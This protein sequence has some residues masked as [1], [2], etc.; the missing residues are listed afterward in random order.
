MPLPI[1]GLVREEIVG[2]NLTT[3]KGLERER[4]KHVESEAAVFLVSNRSFRVIHGM[5][6]DDETLQTSDINHDVIGWKI[7]QD[8]SLRLV[9][10]RKKASKC[11]GQ[12]SDHRNTC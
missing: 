12:T 1:P 7:V 4:C 9:A 6:K 8:I 5:V 3:N 2:H 10:K 11:H